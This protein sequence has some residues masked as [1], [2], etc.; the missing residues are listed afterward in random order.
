M[1]ALVWA[2]IVLMRN[3]LQQGMCI[4]VCPVVHVHTC[5]HVFVHVCAHTHLYGQPRHMGWD[6]PCRGWG[7]AQASS[8]IFWIWGQLSCGWG[9]LPS[10]LFGE[11]FMYSASCSPQWV[12]ANDPVQGREKTPGHQRQRGIAKAHR[13]ET[14][15]W[16]WEGDDAFLSV[17]M[18]VFLFKHQPFWLWCKN[19]LIPEP[20]LGIFRLCLST[21]YPPTQKR[22]CPTLSALKGA[23]CIP[24]SPRESLERAWRFLSNLFFVFRICHF[25]EELPSLDTNKMLLSWAARR[26]FSCPA[27]HDDFRLTLLKF[28]RNRF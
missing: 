12:T 9:S 21:V 24:S 5:R 25:N 19:K 13:T 7:T 4:C 26:W 18:R 11:R 22:N 14:P 8:S 20:W 27:G 17:F 2:L 3:M 23:A 28:K 15:V 16:L 6:C 10:R 1:R